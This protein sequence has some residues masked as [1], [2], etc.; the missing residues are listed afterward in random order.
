[1]TIP[2][3]DISPQELARLA[4]E[5]FIRDVSIIPPPREPQGVL[6]MRAGVFVTLRS[7]EGQLRGCIGT[8]DPTRDSVAEEVIQNAIMVPMIHT[9]SNFSCWGNR[10]EPIVNSSISTIQGKFAS[11]IIHEF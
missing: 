7:Q 2:A 11:A 6:A 8:I 5:A 9:N 10:P 4:V 3:N 1:M